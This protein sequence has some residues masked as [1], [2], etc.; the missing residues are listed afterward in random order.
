ML[1]AVLFDFGDTLINFEPLDTRAVFR[2]AAHKTYDYLRERGVS[3]PGFERYCGRLYRLV[4]WKYVWAKLTGREFNSLDLL[5]GYLTEV[6][7][8]ADEAALLELAWL[9]YLPLKAHTSV[10]AHCAE[11]LARLRDAGLKLGIVSNTFVP[12]AVL[13]RHLQMDGLLEFFPVRVYS[14]EVGYRKPSARIF[15]TALAGL[16]VEAGEAVFVGDLVKTDIVG[17][18]RAGMRTVLKQPWCGRGGGHRLADAVIERLEELPAL[19]ERLGRNGQPARG[20]STLPDP[21][22]QRPLAMERR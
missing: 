3:L 18:R 8:K 15:T 2:E 9:W 13:D 1:R 14:S 16:G 10:E 22:A 11:V 5:R 21:A 12:G 20:V 6:T 7:G 19:L 4:K 17:A